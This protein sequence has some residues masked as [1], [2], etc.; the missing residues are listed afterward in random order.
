MD[1]KGGKMAARDFT[2]QVRLSQ[3]LKDVRLV[4]AA[5][6]RSGAN[7]RMGQRQQIIIPCR[8]GSMSG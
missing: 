6:E 1:V 2:P 4:L 3:H 7:K 8:I 5:G